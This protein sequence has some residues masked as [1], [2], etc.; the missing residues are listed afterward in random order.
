MTSQIEETMEHGR[1]PHAVGGRGVGG[2]KRLARNSHQVGVLGVD[3]GLQMLAVDKPVLGTG[4]HSGVSLV[5]KVQ[6]AVFDRRDPIDASR[7]LGEM[8]QRAAQHDLLHRIGAAGPVSARATVSIAPIA[9]HRP[10]HII[11]AGQHTPG[12]PRVPFT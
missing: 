3:G 4:N 9:V 11:E 2:L 10:D 6:E 12:S 7:G 8:A 5:E 1:E